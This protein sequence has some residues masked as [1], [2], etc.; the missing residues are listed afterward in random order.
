MLSPVLQTIKDV[1]QGLIDDGLVD[2]DKVCVL[3]QYATVL[4]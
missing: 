2:S 4:C 3:L 1:N